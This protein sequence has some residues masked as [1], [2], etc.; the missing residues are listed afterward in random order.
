MTPTAI[1]VEIS[2]AFSQQKQRESCLWCIHFAAAVDR[3]FV[4]ICIVVVFAAAAADRIR[5]NEV[6]L[7]R[8]GDR[9]LTAALAKN[10]RKYI[11]YCVV[12]CN[13]SGRRRMRR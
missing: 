4:D 9:E 2:N 11:W 7:Q 5:C 1:D 3:S 12:L 8:N 6:Q 10:K 13:A